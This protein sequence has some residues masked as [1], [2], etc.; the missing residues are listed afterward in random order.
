MKWSMELFSVSQVQQ[1]LL[2]KYGLSASNAQ[3]VLGFMGLLHDIGY[4]DIDTHHVPKW[5][6]AISSGI[7]VNY[8]LTNWT[9][10][11]GAQLLNGLANTSIVA[12]FVQAIREHNWDDGFCKWTE[13]NPQYYS[14][15]SFNTSGNPYDP[16]SKT[17]PF[18]N[19]NQTYY[20]GYSYGYA[21]SLP[22]KFAIRVAD[23]LDAI[24]SRLT[25]VQNDP[26]L[27]KY[28]YR[29]YVDQPLRKAV[30]SRYNKNLIKFNFFKKKLKPFSSMKK[31]SLPDDQLN[32]FRN[33]ARARA[34]IYA[35]LQNATDDQKKVMNRADEQSFLHF[36]SNYV[37]DYSSISSDSW[38]IFVNLIPGSGDL[39]FD[40]HPGPGLYQINRLATSALS[41]ITEGNSTFLD[42][43]RF[44]FNIPLPDLDGANYI[45]LRAFTKKPVYDAHGQAI[46]PDGQQEE[47]CDPFCDSTTIA[48]TKSF[49]A[50]LAPD[51]SIPQDCNSIDEAFA[52]IPPFTDLTYPSSSSSPSSSESN[53]LII[54]I[55]IVA[56]VAGILLVVNIFLI[57]KFALPNKKRGEYTE[58]K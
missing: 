47:I 55:I 19:S 13:N 31:K 29:I 20:R 35:N 36:Y 23:N 52:Q 49:E 12:D 2:N 16:T 4:A 32:S 18:L 30:G 51:N 39:N 46:Y 8:Y 34:T 48:L 6:H 17:T 45:P 5:L 3:F 26:Q 57:I 56:V 50:C 38:S 43:V 40:S 53:N 33:D 27:M 44:N 11:L 58:I 9:N 14:Q 41:C 15:C 42:L 24:R 1:G 21:L 10:G 54:I 37:I 7:M 25:P 28:F 22:L